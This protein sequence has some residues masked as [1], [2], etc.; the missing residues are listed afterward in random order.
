M[1]VFIKNPETEA[2]IRELAARTGETLTDAIDRSVAERLAKLE[3]PHRQGRVDRLKLAEQLAYFG[4][5]KRINDDL[6]DDDI[7]GYDD[8]GLPR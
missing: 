2:R 8:N 6:T 1:G 4:S 3:P 7:I 5:L